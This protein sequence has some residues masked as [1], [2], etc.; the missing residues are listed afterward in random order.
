WQELGNLLKVLGRAAE[1]L[2]HLPDQLVDLVAEPS[3]RQSDEHGV[4]AEL[5]GRRLRA[6][7]LE[8]E[9]RRHDLPLLF[10]QRAGVSRAA[11][12]TSAA[13]P[14]GHRLRAPEVLAERPYLD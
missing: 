9:R 11:A 6:I 3:L 7:A 1:P 12:A 10:G 13:A 8:V 4:L 2:H 14:A 5:V